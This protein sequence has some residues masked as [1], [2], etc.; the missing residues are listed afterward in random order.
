MLQ[1]KEQAMLNIGCEQLRR[2]FLAI[3]SFFPFWW[4]ILFVEVAE[5]DMNMIAG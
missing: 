1:E 3:C 2:T 4:S 5:Q